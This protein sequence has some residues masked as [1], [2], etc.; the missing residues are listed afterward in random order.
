MAS[1][2]KNLDTTKS[3]VRRT[4]QDK[5]KISIIS[6]SKNRGAGLLGV[7]HAEAIAEAGGTLALWDINE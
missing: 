6:P 7:Q 1:I 5:P 4:M 2:D 3:Q